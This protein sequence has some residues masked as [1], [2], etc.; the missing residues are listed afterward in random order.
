[1]VDLLHPS[2]EWVPFETNEHLRYRLNY[3]GVPV[4]TGVLEVVGDEIFRGH[5]VYHVRSQAWSNW[6]FS[7][8]YEVRDMAHSYID[9]KGLFSRGFEQDNYE[10]G[11]RWRSSIYYDQEGLVAYDEIQNY[12]MDIPKGIQ[13]PLSCLYSLRS[14]P[15]R[16]GETITIPVNADKKN[17]NVVVKVLRK[18]RVKV[19]AGEFNTILVEPFLKFKGLFRREGRLLIWLTDDERK[20]PVLMK[21]RIPIGSVVAK[22][23]R[24]EK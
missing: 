10:N 2:R 23:E 11:K 7:L 5:E 19:P 4:G 24:H 20:I 3:L 14:M 17:W 13:D 18:E 8:F 21:C 1:M 9:K 15:I 22:L 16:I 6:F 12:K